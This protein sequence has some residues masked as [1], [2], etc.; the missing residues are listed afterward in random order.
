MDQISQLKSAFQSLGLELGSFALTAVFLAI[1]VALITQGVY[2]LGI[3][4]RLNKKALYK[5]FIRLEHPLEVKGQP[6]YWQMIFRSLFGRSNIFQLTPEQVS[7]QVSAMARASLDRITM[8][9]RAREGAYT[10]DEMIAMTLANVSI[11]SPPETIE[12]FDKLNAS[13]KGGEREDLPPAY[14][15]VADSIERGVDDLHSYLTREW[16]RWDYLLTAVVALFL[17]FFVTVT[18]TEFAFSGL[19]VVMTLV[20]AAVSTFIAVPMRVALFRV[21]QGDR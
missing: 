3:R 6:E 2:D 10:P 4:R 14:H 7:A 8:V 17:A 13:L 18:S 15:I 20:V 16:V 11:Q 19:G 9:Y 1:L 12:Y 21:L 5:W